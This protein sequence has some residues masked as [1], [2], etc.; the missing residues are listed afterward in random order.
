MIEIAKIKKTSSV[1]S[2]KTKI[3]WMSLTN[4]FTKK[5]YSKAQM[6]KNHT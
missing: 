2:K 3:S 6:L 5:I 4:Y 1:K